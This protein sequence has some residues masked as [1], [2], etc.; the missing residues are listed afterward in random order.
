MRL[1]LFYEFC[2]GQG[3]PSPEGADRRLFE[4]VLEQARLG[5]KA[6]F[7][8]FWSVEHHG[9]VEVTHMPAPEIFLTAVAM[10]TERLRVG[11]GVVLT[12]PLFN[13]P[14]RVAERAAVLDNLSGGRLEMGFG[15]STP[16]EWAIFRIDGD[17]TRPILEEVLEIM[18]RMWMEESFTYE[19]KYFQ[20]APVTIVPRI[21]QKPHPR[22]WI[23]AGSDESLELAG[24]A[25]VGVLSLTLLR[26]FT[27]LQKS[28]EI[29][30]KA[31][32]NQTP[33]SPQLINNQAGAFTFVYVAETEDEAIHDGACQAAAW[34]LT[35]VFALYGSVPVKE[36]DA[37]YHFARDREAQLAAITAS[38]SSPGREMLIKM[39]DE[40]PVTPEEFYEAMDSENQMIVGTPDHV[41]EKLEEY[42]GIGLDR[43]MCMVMGGPALSQEKILKSMELIGK[44]VIPHFHDRDKRS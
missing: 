39:V 40:V 36:G 34:Y 37:G 13:H 4:D 14:V 30:R 28:L 10:Q 20:I 32:E 38:G 22:M 19:G 12:H 17:E 24:R 25:G 29:Y 16:R 6:G 3:F 11:H 43:M 27:D 42:E 35:K 9:S 31:Q 5:D 15:R 26:P 18:P 21:Y 8:I 7:D 33:V 2:Q 23:A 44:S 1:D 41:I